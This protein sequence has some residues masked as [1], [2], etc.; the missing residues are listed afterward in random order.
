M[1]LDI[2]IEDEGWRAIRG[3]KRRTHEALLLALGRR[4]AAV[5]VLFTSDRAVKKLNGAWRGKN[6][7]TNVLSFPAAGM[8][9]PRGQPKPLG[10][11]VLAY[12]VVARE[13]KAQGKTL[14]A[15]TMHL[16]VHGALHLLDYDH[17]SDGEA[18]IMEQRE[19]RLL[20]RLGIE[21]PYAP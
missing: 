20:A 7:P 6:K 5:S 3:L 18:R 2:S 1:K 16:L 4:K 15:H 9:I 21:N 13:A 8:P 14:A 12:G 10:D 17:E 19:I 11:I